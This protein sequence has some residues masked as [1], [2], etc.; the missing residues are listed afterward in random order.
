MPIQQPVS[1]SCKISCTHFESPACPTL[2]S[3]CREWLLPRLFSDQ[4][5]FG[6]LEV[7]AKIQRENSPSW[8]CYV[9]FSFFYAKVFSTSGPPVVVFNGSCQRECTS[10]TKKTSMFFFSAAKLLQCIHPWKLTCPLKRGHFKRKGSSSNYYFSGE[11][12]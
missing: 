11:I 7:E 5:L 8:G 12:P 6:E 2:R 10:F 4:S 1:I 3:Y 9:F